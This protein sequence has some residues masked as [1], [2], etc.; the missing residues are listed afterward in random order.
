MP[1]SDKEIRYM[2]SNKTSATCDKNLHKIECF[3]LVGKGIM[4]LLIN[5]QAKIP[6]QEG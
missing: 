5:I 6:Y 4:I 2:T 3:N 1:L